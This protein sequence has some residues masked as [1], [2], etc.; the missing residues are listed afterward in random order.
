MHPR[1]T[2]PALTGAVVLA[3][4]ASIGSQRPAL[5]D[6]AAEVFELPTVQV[7]GTTPLP[8]LGVPA[9]DVPANVQIFGADDLG[10]LQTRSLTRFLSEGAGS[11][12][13]GSG[14]GNPFQQSLDFRGLTASPLLGTPQGLSV[15]QDG[16]RINEAFGDVV[17]WDLLPR[18]AISSIQLLPGSVPA[19]GLNTLGGALAIYTK[20]GADYP[21]ASVEVSGG[22]FGAREG[23][24]EAGG[25]RGNIDGFVTA[26]AEDDRGWAD[27]NPTQLR[28]LF[29]KVGYQ[30]DR[31]DLDVSLTLADNRLQGTQT[32]PLSF[33]DDPKQAYTYPDEND[34]KLAFLAAKGSHFISD[35]MLVGGNAYFRHYQSANLSS[36]VN[37][38]FG[39]SDAP[40]RAAFEALN[41]RSDIDQRSWGAGLQ[42]TSNG[43]VADRANQL[44]IGA[45]GDFGDTEFRQ[46]EQLA[47]FTAD[48]G[49]VGAGSYATITDVALRNAYTGIFATDTLNLTPRW[50]LTLAGRYNHAHVVVTDRSGTAPALDGDSNFSRFNPAVGIN[51]NPTPTLTAYAGYNEGMRAPTPIELTCA[52]P[53][54]PCKLPNEFLADPP[55]AK[56]VSKTTETGARGK[57]G[58]AIDWS[59]ALF[60]TDLDND[61]EFIAAGAGAT[62][63]GYFQNVGKT[64]RQ[65]IEAGVSTRSG[66]LRVSLRYSHL[67][68]TFRSTFSAA[69]ADNSTADANGAIRVRPG[70][71]IPGIPADS[72]KLRV[73]YAHG[74]FSL[75]T[76]IFAAASQY[77]HGDENNADVHGRVP[78]YAV[79]GLDA[80]YQASPKLEIF[81]SVDNL[82]DRRY[83]NFGLLG[84]NVFNGPN[85]SFG[86]AAGVD[87]VSEQ[88]VALG[89]P[90]TITVGL[91]WR[92]DTPG[93]ASGRS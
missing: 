90:R 52:D 68:A 27:H 82:L 12:D 1:R 13:V 48:R 20:S 41:D 72:V 45:S 31:N 88:F 77:A 67:N 26:H 51:Y 25:A 36:N 76:G 11:V 24:F 80:R 92:F 21:G 79:V 2:P 75:A 14:Q 18:S 17:N 34:N 87:P 62:N 89:A 54:A 15:F 43:R 6:N 69:S 39:S 56:V 50:T 86:P 22:S 4:A 93:H 29:G 85:R 57:L 55:L 8:G 10:P 91:R 38:D 32:L 71:K 33:L 40:G 66:P 70:D 35:D 23:E 3:L 64:R 74:P 60:R 9:R 49:A 7:V 81:A 42:L 63:A 19:Y 46:N 65:G 30:D 78:G 5:A 73:E 58:G 16:V 83:A 53:S 28:Q 61:I 59:A 37:D 84:S 44:A 47:N